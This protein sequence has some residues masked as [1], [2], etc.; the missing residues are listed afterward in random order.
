MRILARNFKKGTVK[1]VPETLDDLWHLYNIILA[2]DLVYARTTRQKKVDTEYSRP[3]KGKRVSLFLG[4][5]V[6]EVVWDRSVNIL[7]IQGRIHEAP[8]DVAGRG[9]HHTLKAAIGKA[10]SITKEKWLKSHVTRLE[11]ARLAK[12]E[13]I[14]VV[15]IDSE[16]FCIAMIMQYGIDVKVEHKAGLPGKLEVEKRAGAFKRYFR[17]ALRA[18]SEL[19]NSA[20]CSI[21]IIGVGFVKTQFVNEVRSEAPEIAEAI[22]DVKGVNNTGESGIYEALRSGVLDKALRQGRI[23]EEAQAVEEVLARLGR[24]RRDVSYGLEQ[25]ELADQFGAVETLLVADSTIREALKQNR[26]VLEQMM[27]RIE[28]RSGRVIIVSEEHEAGQ[29]LLALGGIAALLRFPIN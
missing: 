12:A 7:R 19:W 26:M 4:V 14:I 6:E 25:V 20:K 28:Q 17:T 21:V 9:S 8:N 10:I 15:S 18:L 16:G 27:I 22:V 24:E 5:R 2:D 13:P 11:R 23:A 1:V 3:Q 29:K